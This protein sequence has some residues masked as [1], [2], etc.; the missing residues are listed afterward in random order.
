MKKLALVFASMVIAFALN[1]QTPEKK[2]CCKDKAKTECCSKDAKKECDKS[3]E[4]AN[5]CTKGKADTKKNKK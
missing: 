4:S 5:C 1:A 2:E 3:S